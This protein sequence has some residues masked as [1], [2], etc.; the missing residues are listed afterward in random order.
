MIKMNLLTHIYTLRGERLMMS[1]FGTRI[2][3]LVFEPLTT[4]VVELIRE[5]LTAVCKYDPRV[6]LM[7]LT[8][9]PA[10]DEGAVIANM[11]LKFIELDDID[12]LSVSI[13]FE[14]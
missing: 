13:T 5:D 14:Q 12:D 1:T 3:E 7:E 6:E 9:T 8:V 2:P 4:E 10:W 11:K